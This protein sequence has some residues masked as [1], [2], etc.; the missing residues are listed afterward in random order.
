MNTIRKTLAFA[1]VLPALLAGCATPYVP[2]K[3]E[4]MASVAV[5]GIGSLTMCRE[6]KRHQ[7]WR[8][9]GVVQVPVGA[10]IEI[11]S[12]LQVDGGNVNWSCQSAVEFTPD[13][14]TAY[15]F[16]DGYLDANRCF[17]ELVKQDASA[18]N[19][20]AVVASARRGTCR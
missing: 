19:G 20:V 3:G 6:G 9:Q 17:V 13:A 14:D 4:P 2:A 16:N 8:K 11:A 15:V 12:R 5:A 18:A 1:A 10:P 7:L